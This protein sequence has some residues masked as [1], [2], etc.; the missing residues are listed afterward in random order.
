[1]V[2]DGRYRYALVTEEIE[3]DLGLDALESA[4]RKTLA[5][6]TGFEPVLPA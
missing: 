4:S 1:M 3:D 2:K 6:P 5:T